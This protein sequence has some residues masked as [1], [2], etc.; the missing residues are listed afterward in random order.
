MLKER[1]VRRDIGVK[2]SLTLHALA[3]AGSGPDI[4]RW[5]KAIKYR[6]EGLPPG[7]QAWIAEMNH[8]WRILLVKD[9]FGK[10]IGKHKTPEDALAALA[11]GRR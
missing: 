3:D 9:G 5:D 4:P 11:D 7:Q 10:W 2:D 8:T 6:G 1:F